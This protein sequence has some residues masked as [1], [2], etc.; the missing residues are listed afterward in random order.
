MERKMKVS[1]ITITLNSEKTVEE[2]FKSVLKQTYRPLEYLIIDGKSTDTTLDIIEKYKPRF[3]DAG[4]ELQFVSEKDKGISD[5]FNKGIRKA[6]GDIIG[7]INSDDM[8]CDDA[9]E[10]LAQNV[11][12]DTDVYYGDC[13]VINDTSKKRFLV[14]PKNDLERLKVSMCIYHPATF[15]MKRTYDQY[16]AFKEDLKYCMDRELLLR[17]YVNKCKFEYI[18][19]PLAFYRE[20]GVNQV[21]YKKN[22]DEGTRISVEY[23]MNPILAYLEKVKKLCKYM[24]WRFVQKTGMERFVHKMQ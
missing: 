16:G 20:G 19:E 8:L 24:I 5:A 12:E 10:I 17:F 4:I 21:N 14:T 1:I 3:E 13:V 2:T 7:I 18:P 11:K 15:V 23:G 6:T 9:L 22:V